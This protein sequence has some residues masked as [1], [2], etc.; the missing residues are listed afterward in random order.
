MNF[1]LAIAICISLILSI[2]L[3]NVWSYRHKRKMTPAERLKYDEENRQEDR[4]W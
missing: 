1:A 4:I 3:L 2:F